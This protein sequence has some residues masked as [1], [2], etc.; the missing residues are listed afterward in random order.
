MASRKRP[1]DPK[2]E[3]PTNGIDTSMQEIKLNN[4]N[5]NSPTVEDLPT[6]KYVST[7]RVSCCNFEMINV[8]N[9]RRISIISHISNDFHK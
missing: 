2:I 1:H 3:M 4:A 6:I 5:G 9:F 7:L 8:R